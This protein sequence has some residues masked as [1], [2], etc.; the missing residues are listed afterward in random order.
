MPGEALRSARNLSPKLSSPDT[1]LAIEFDPPASFVANRSCRKYFLHWRP[2]GLDPT[3]VM[4]AVA[5]GWDANLRKLE[6]RASADF[7]D[8]EDCDG[9]VVWPPVCRAP[10]LHDLLSLGARN[11]FGEPRDRGQNRRYR[12]LDQQ[13]RR[14]PRTQSCSGCRRRTIAA[15][16]W[17][18]AS[19]RCSRGVV[20]PVC[21]ARF[22]GLI[23]AVFIGA[24][25]AGARNG[26][27]EPRD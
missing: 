24:T 25:W 10:G 5:A 9:I 16:D 8:V 2:I 17:R 14:L 6:F 22:V 27:A 26:F 13:Q 12:G 21:D 18:R 20:P 3:T 7:G 11:G 23:L 19:A 1:L 4:A 15:G